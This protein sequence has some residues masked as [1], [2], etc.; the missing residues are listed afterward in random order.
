MKLVSSIFGAR[1]DSAVSDAASEAIARE[2]ETPVYEPANRATSAYDEVDESIADAIQSDLDLQADNQNADDDD[3]LD[4]DVD[5]S[6]VEDISA[7]IAADAAAHEPE[8]HETE[9]R[10]DDDLPLTM[11][12]ERSFGDDIGSN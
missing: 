10:D 12:E 4:M 9:D 6:L 2:I 3:D 7:E 8:M 11:T 5:V 1:K